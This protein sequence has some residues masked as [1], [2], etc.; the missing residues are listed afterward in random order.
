M[1][2]TSP[3]LLCTYLVSLAQLYICH[4]ILPLFILPCDLDI[5][6]FHYMTLN[7]WHCF[8]IIYTESHTILHLHWLMKLTKLG[9]LGETGSRE[10][11]GGVLERAPPPRALPHVFSC[12][13]DLCTHLLLQV[14]WY[15]S[16][17]NCFSLLSGSTNAPLVWY[18]VVLWDGA[19]DNCISIKLIKC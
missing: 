15:L 11:L 18:V 1:T 9:L 8:R 10:N 14:I 17:V 4:L 5:H 16:T 7:S 6:C 3:A 12:S 2:L 19:Q 13:W